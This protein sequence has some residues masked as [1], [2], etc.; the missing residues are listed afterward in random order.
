MKIKEFY[1]LVV[2]TA[3]SP[4]ASLEA[5]S[6]SWYGPPISSSRRTVLF[7]TLLC[8]VHGRPTTEDENYPSQPPAHPCP[9]WSCHR[10]TS[11]PQ[12]SGPTQ[13]ALGPDPTLGLHVPCPTHVCPGVDEGLLSAPVLVLPSPNS[14]LGSLEHTREQHV[15]PPPP[16]HTCLLRSSTFKSPPRFPVFCGQQ[17]RRW[18]H[19]PL[20]RRLCCAEGSRSKP[21]G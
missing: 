4:Q 15:S 14:Q 21:R 12:S 8:V 6:P 1:Q 5:L 3:S 10:Y 17:G 18:P 9:L 2:E 11:V 13:G 20:G 7:L 16:S 19:F